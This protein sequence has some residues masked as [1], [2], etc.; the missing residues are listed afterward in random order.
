MYDVVLVP[1]HGMGKT[2]RRFDADLRKE[3]SDEMRDDWERVLVAPVYYQDVLQPNQSRV[4]KKMKR[5]DLDWIKLRTFVLYGFSDAAGLEHRANE[6]GSPYMETQQKIWDALEGAYQL[7]GRSVPVV[8]VAQSLGGQ[9]ISNYLWD[10]QARSASRGVWRRPPSGME[11]DLKRFLKLKTLSHLYTT[12]CNIPIFVAGFPED[13]I[14][15]VKHDSDGYGFE[16]WNYY[17]ADDALGWPLRPLNTAYRRAVRA[18]REVNADGGGFWGRVS[19]GWNPLSHKR[20][21]TDPDVVRP[22]ARHLKALIHP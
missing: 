1:I 3:L 10:A 11:R 14:V 20:Y 6:E 21:W 17:D 12:G 18:D 4:M 2:S 8:I 13:D 19:H 5:H 15:P 7:I 9:V 22:L 16:W